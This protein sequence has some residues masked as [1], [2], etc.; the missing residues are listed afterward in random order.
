L[1]AFGGAGKKAVFCLKFGLRDG[2]WKTFFEGNFQG[3]GM[4][5]LMNPG[6][7]MLVAIYDK[8][9]DEIAGVLLQA[10]SVFSAVGEAETFIESLQREAVALLRHD[11]KHTVQ[12]LAFASKPAYAKASEDAVIST[13]ETVLAEANESAGKMEKVAASFDLH[14]TPLSK[15]SS[16][17]KQAFFS[18]PFAVPMLA[19]EAKRIEV[20][21][22]EAGIQG[23]AEG[24]AVVLGTGKTG[25]Q[26]REPLALFQRTLVSDGTAVQRAGFARIIVESYLLG[27]TPAVVFDEA[28][29]FSGLKYPTKMI[30]ELQANGIKTEPIG[31]PTRDFEAGKSIKANLNVISAAGFLELFGCVDKEPEKI[32]SEALKKG[33]VESPSQLIDSIESTGTNENTNPF[34]KRRLQRIVKLSEVIYPELFGGAN[35]IE[36]IVQSWFKKIGKASII[37]V[38]KTDPRALTFFLDSLAQE[39]VVFFSKQGETQ[40]AKLLVAIPQIEKVFSIKDSLV[41]NDLIKMLTEMKR[42]GI[43]FIIGTDKK[44]DLSKE[45]LQLA[46]TKVSIIKEN[47]AAID[48][49]NTKSYRV[50][51]R[52]SLSEQQ[53]AQGPVKG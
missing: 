40:K 7:A 28:G 47:D 2:P 41:L 43:S 15:S 49:P 23:G 6:Q 19:R 10:F 25:K 35:N 36:E 20:E 11:G 51:L 27:N 31:F 46:E 29:A 24:S 34:I 18:Q 52:P 21:Q 37:N 3:H 4:E 48:F 50:L 42:F 39:I 22:Q 32:L 17:V 38:G 53:A 13:A 16:A 14:L 8:E 1:K 44:G 30:S 9:G 5:I 33:S 45:L 26:A 12:F